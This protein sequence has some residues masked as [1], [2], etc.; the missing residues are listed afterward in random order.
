MYWFV[1]A[2]RVYTLLEPNWAQWNGPYAEK[3][4]KC[5]PCS[6]GGGGVPSCTRNFNKK[7]TNFN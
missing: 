4:S 1:K 3:Q 5:T 6:G 2:P 7:C